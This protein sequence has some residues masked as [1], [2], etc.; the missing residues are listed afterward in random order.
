M[1]EQ[2]SVVEMSTSMETQQLTVSQNYEMFASTNEDAEVT[3]PVVL[4]PA[5]EGKDAYLVLIGCSML[6]LPIWGFS[7][8]YGVFQEYYSSNPSWQASSST[9]GIIGTTLT[10]SGPFKPRPD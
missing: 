7:I 4:L 2:S 8:S 3:R 6:Q 1:E 5:D 9:T 10:V